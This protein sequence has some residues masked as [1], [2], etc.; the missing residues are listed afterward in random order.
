MYSIAFDSNFSLLTISFLF[1]FLNHTSSNHTN[2]KTSTRT[3][4]NS[5][6][7]HSSCRLADTKNSANGHSVSGTRSTIVSNGKDE[8]PE[9]GK[10]FFKKNKVTH[11][12]S[13]GLRSQISIYDTDVRIRSGSA[14]SSGP[15]R[16]NSQVLKKSSLTPL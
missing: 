10:K 9:A 5:L 14:S 12:T 6:G 8:T 16:K 11:A 2:S 4:M 3:S 7:Y 13:N 1:Q 15:Y